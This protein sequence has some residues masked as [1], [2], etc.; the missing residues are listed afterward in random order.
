M[1]IRVG[2]LVTAKIVDI[3]NKRDGES[4][5]MRKELVGCV[6]ASQLFPNMQVSMVLTCLTTDLEIT[7]FAIP[8]QLSFFDFIYFFARA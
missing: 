1:K 3:E 4:I 7:R 2:S 6:Q 5:S 8:L